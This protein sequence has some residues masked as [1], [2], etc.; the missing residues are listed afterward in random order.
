MRPGY[1]G[2]TPHAPPERRG[3]LP[4]V[5]RPARPLPIRELRDLLALAGPLIA[6]QLAQ[7]GMNTVDTV[8]AGRLGPDALA[9]IALGGVIYQSTLILGMGVLFAVAPLV[10]Q[11]L[12]AD[13]PDDAGRTARQGLWLALLMGV[14]V[15]LLLREVG[16]L[17]GRLGQ[18]PGTVALAG[19]YLDAVAFGYLPALAL[20]AARGF[21]EGI[22][23]A[24]PIMVV[25]LAGIAAN[26][27]ANDALMFGRYGLPALGLVGTGVATAL[28]YTGMAAALYAYV[29]LR[30]RRYRVLRGLRRPDPRTLATIFALG[31][32]IG[33]TLGFEA[34]L[35][36]ITAILMGTFGPDA[37]A[38]HQI[39]IQA[40]SVT[41]MVPVGLA[42]ATGV[43][44]A[45][46]A[47][48]RDR[49][50]VRRAGLTGIATA[51]AFMSVTALVF[52]FAPALVVAAFLDPGAPGNAATARYAV[53][54]LGLAAVFQVVDGIQVTASGALRGL[55][56]TRVPMLLSFVSY[57]VVGLGSGVLLAFVA[58]LQ[59]RGLWIGLV[60]GLATAATL[61][62]TRFLRA[63]RPGASGLADAPDAPSAGPP[64]VDSPA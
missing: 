45:R 29:A 42:N 57:G 55:R 27:V 43:R 9:G 56:D 23:D 53:T 36:S 26:V 49:D 14:P 13:R 25:L 41:F 51:I 24:R 21:L 48:A 10:S 60:I 1:P 12:G 39:A 44:V 4:G 52:R 18:D 19:G 54:F 32:P 11:A 62:T 22:G 15:T 38:G 2:R 59:G 46:A 63:T 34:A 61:L 7:I 20:V 5:R 6:A 3:S 8:M 58:D 47:G 16:P 17:L 35:F 37:L 28:V 31:W 40:A 33:L 64:G 50:G 30:H